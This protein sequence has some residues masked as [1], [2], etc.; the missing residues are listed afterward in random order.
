MLAIERLTYILGVCAAV[1]SW[2][3]NEAS[4]SLSKSNNVMY[5]V[6]ENSP[7][8]KT[9]IVENLS[10]TVNF[11]NFVFRLQ[12][13]KE[14][15]GFHIRF[16]AADLA[17]DLVEEPVIFN[18]AATVTVSDF[19]PGAIVKFISEWDKDCITKPSLSFDS[20]GDD[21]ISN[22][23]L[24]EPGIESMIIKYHF[25]II[26][27]IIVFF[28][29]V[30]LITYGASLFL[31][32]RKVEF[33]VIPSYRHRVVNS[34]QP[35]TQRVQNARINGDMLCDPGYLGRRGGTR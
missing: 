13:N 35:I 11:G 31:R 27:V 26:M 21:K 9:F 29:V 6:V 2:S 33:R 10:K 34:L 5:D 3:A 24:L 17:P 22:I 4:Q 16:H 20:N 18:S 14:N 28:S 15:C 19:P 1:I 32:L 7:N 23:R 8:N 12:G 30:F 25:I